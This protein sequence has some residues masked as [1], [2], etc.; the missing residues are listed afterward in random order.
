MEYTDYEEDYAVK[1]NKNNLKQ[2]DSLVK[3]EPMEKED[4]RTKDSDSNSKQSCTK[5]IKHNYVEYSQE[6]SCHGV[7]KISDTGRGL[8]RR[9]VMFN[10]SISLSSRPYIN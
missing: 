10:E 4:H 8:A 9:L 6:T 5:V 3:M 2:P 7:A 1:Q